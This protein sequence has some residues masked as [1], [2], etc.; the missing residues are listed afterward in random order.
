MQTVQKYW[1]LVLD[2]DKFFP[3]FNAPF[4]AN[5][6][7]LVSAIIPIKQNINAGIYATKLNT[8][9][10]CSIILCKQCV[11]SLCNYC[12]KS[13]IYAGIYA[14]KLNAENFLL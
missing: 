12:M 10:V 4:S 3:V 5:Q 8:S 7:F 2:A 13:K 9:S 1:M 14:A 6:V 11:S